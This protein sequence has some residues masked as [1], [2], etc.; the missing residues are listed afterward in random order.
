MADLEREVPSQGKTL[1]LDRC[2]VGK[3][4]IPK[5]DEDN[6]MDL[7]EGLHYATD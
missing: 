5:T 3:V 4:R 2:V 7:E 6:E 1:R